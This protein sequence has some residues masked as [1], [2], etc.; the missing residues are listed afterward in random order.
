MKRPGTALNPPTRIALRPLQPDRTATTMAEDV[1]GGLSMMPKQLPCKYFYDSKGSLLFEQICHT[2]EYYPWRT[3]NNLLAE[4]ATAIIERAAPRT[5]IELGSGSSRK[6]RHLLRASESAGRYPEYV[7]VDVCPQMLIAA[8]ED[9]AAEYEWL[10]IS[11]VA[12]DYTLGFSRLATHASPAL[13]VFLGGTVGN[14]T[15]G[16]LDRFLSNIYQTMHPGDFL[17][18]GADLEKEE[19]VLHAAYNDTAG[20]TGAF[21]LNVL[22]VINRELEG[23]FQTDEFV[24]DAQYN[25]ARSRV[26]MHL[27]SRLRQSVTLRRCGATFSFSAG[28]PVLTEI[29]RKFTVSRL[30][31]LLSASGLTVDWVQTAP[32][33]SFALLLAARRAD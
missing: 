19:Q 8:A 22:D 27:V 12:G 11:A 28:E 17:L 26:E 33:P 6:T 4:A 23:N 24:H 3:E 18:L 25:V 5:I 21:N 31:A 29:S 14:F 9:L 15:D 7:P 1:V 20:L 10:S 30:R 16:E 13:F 2:P 32:D